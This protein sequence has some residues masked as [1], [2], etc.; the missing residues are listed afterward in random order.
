MGELSLDW[1]GNARGEKFVGSRPNLHLGI[2]MGGT[3]QG[4][5]CRLGRDPTKDLLIKLRIPLYS[6][7]KEHTPR[8]ARHL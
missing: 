7:L 8:H 4:S 2:S 5:E 6:A 3:E 1:G